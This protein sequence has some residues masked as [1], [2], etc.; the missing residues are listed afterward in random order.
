M[1]CDKHSE[2]K[3][4]FQHF[5]NLHVFTYTYHTMYRSLAKEGP[6]AVN[7]TLGSDRGVADI[8]IAII[9][10]SPK[11]SPGLYSRYRS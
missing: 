2:E 8:S 11:D 4:S 3:T 1:A 5:I 10:L 6:W 9:L 7:L